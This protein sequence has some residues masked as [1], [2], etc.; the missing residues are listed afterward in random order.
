MFGSRKALLKQ[1]SYT[2]R[3][4]SVP[5]PYT[6][7]T[8][9]QDGTPGNGDRVQAALLAASTDREAAQAALA[10]AKMRQDET[11]EELSWCMKELAQLQKEKN[12]WRCNSWLE[13]ATGR[14]TVLAA[15][16]GQESISGMDE[17]DTGNAIQQAKQA[18][19]SASARA[20]LDVQLL[21]AEQQS[22]ELQT[23]LRH[24]EVRVANAEAAQRSA[25]SERD[26]LAQEHARLEEQLARQQQS[27]RQ[28]EGQMQLEALVRSRDQ[29]VSSLSHRLHRQQQELNMTVQR[30]TAQEQSLQ[31]SLSQSQKEREQLHFELQ[32]ARS[33]LESHASDRE[34]MQSE[35]SSLQQALQRQTREAEQAQQVHDSW[36]TRF[37]AQEEELKALQHSHQKLQQQLEGQVEWWRGQ[38]DELKGQ[39]RG[40]ATRVLDLQKKAYNARMAQE[41]ATQGQQAAEASLQQATSSLNQQQ[42]SLQQQHAQQ[43]QHAQ[44]MADQVT[45]LREECAVLTR[46]KDAAETSAAAATQLADC[47]EAQSAQ[48]QRELEALRQQLQANKTSEAA[49]QA[50]QDRLDQLQL[51]HT[52]ELESVKAEL[53]QQQGSHAE[54]LES[55][56]SELAEMSSRA[57]AFTQLLEVQQQRDV[58]VSEAQESSKT[59]A[60]ALAE[61]Q[62]EVQRLQA[63]Q[64]ELIQQLSTTQTQLVE[65]RQELDSAQGEVK[66]SGDERQ[67]LVESVDRL[68]AVAAT[69]QAAKQDLAA[70]QTERQNALGKLAE[71]E[72]ILQQALDQR[73][74]ASEEAHRSQ[75]QVAAQ[76]DELRASQQQLQRQQQELALLQQEAHQAAE[77]KQTIQ[78]LQQ[79]LHNNKVAARQSEQQL[80]EQVHQLR[81]S[82]SDKENSLVQL[83]QRCQST[84]IQLQTLQAVGCERDSTVRQLSGQVSSLRAQAN[85][86]RLIKERLQAAVAAALSGEISCLPGLDSVEVEQQST[87]NADS[88]GSA[89][90]VDLQDAIS[91]LKERSDNVKSLMALPNT[92]LSRPPRSPTISKSAILTDSEAHTHSGE[93]CS[94][95][96]GP[97]QLQ[98]AV[99]HIGGRFGSTAEREQHPPGSSGRQ[100]GA[101]NGSSESSELEN[102][103]V[104]KRPLHKKGAPVLRRVQS[105]AEPSL[106]QRGQPV[107]H[108]SRSSNSTA[109]P[110]SRLSGLPGKPYLG[111]RIGSIDVHNGPHKVS[112]GRQ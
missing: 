73:T 25:E 109:N 47:A 90:V 66:R 21:A 112:N 17:H 2:A 102:R 68:Q 94:S 78:Q 26:A 89:S 1:S 20:G 32:Q 27:T 70:A 100:D 49:D 45:C 14:S 92:G 79:Q 8:R 56:R 29:E 81:R 36:M 4:E 57:A 6:L 48:L 52:Q 53:D 83:Q 62:E 99:R 67:H 86:H 55:V 65:S 15:T 105:S 96:Q 39:L 9:P 80:Q 30:N 50:M 108:S 12:D 74:Q 95:A 76:R 59:A 33:A 88:A 101:S 44:Q 7:G 97:Q 23:Q 110:S 87:V 28:Q 104:L 82:S 11:A 111:S 63:A 3:G 43:A 54:H 103:E 18:A 35:A 38:V 98:Q 107:L 34:Y 77:F 31:A 24:Q 22:Q 37:Q 5:G 71:L 41:A 10:E 16:P 40:E 69:V 91:S 58:A 64:E 85:E 51:T 106:K 84:E 42:H 61:T 72:G 19:A 60:T 75:S 93:L 13:Q 46:H